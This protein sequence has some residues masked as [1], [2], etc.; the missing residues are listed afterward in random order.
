MSQEAT[1]LVTIVRVL[2]K[3][4]DWQQVLKNCIVMNG[5]RSL[6]GT[7][8]WEY[9]GP[10]GRHY[11]AIDLRDVRAKEAFV[12]N[13]E[14]LGGCV[15][16]YISRAMIRK[17]AA[18]ESS[19]RGI[20]PHRSKARH[21]QLKYFA[22]HAVRQEEVEFC[23]RRLAAGCKGQ[24]TIEGEKLAFTII[25]LHA[26]LLTEQNPELGNVVDVLRK[27]KEGR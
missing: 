27:A 16:G 5:P 6:A 10:Y 20:L 22:D 23:Y 12:F 15:M 26:I 17:Y 13:I 4:P 19:K 14:R 21:W 1:R 9:P 18:E 8:H 2:D 7:Y 3:R 25:Y 11:T 24:G